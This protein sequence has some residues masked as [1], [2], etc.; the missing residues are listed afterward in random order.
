[1]TNITG[2]I[3]TAEEALPAGACRTVA[4]AISSNGDA[5]IVFLSV[6]VNN[7]EN[8]IIVFCVE[9]SEKPS[10]WAAVDYTL[11]DSLGGNAGAERLG[12]QFDAD[13]NGS[14]LKVVWRPNPKDD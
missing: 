14:S 4:L 12:M 2:L 5:A 7:E 13:P 9:T 6:D 3:R 8:H 10:G 11:D 1:L